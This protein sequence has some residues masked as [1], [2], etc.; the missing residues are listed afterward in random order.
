VRYLPETRGQWLAS[1]IVLVLVASGI[2]YVVGDRE[3]RPARASV[4]VGFLDDMI[5]HHEQAVQLS[6]IQLFNGAER[7][8]TG[9]ARRI[10]AGQSYEI[11]LM[12]RKLEEWHHARELRPAHAMAWMGMRVRSPL[13]MPGMASESEIETLS[14]ATGR[15]ND[16]LFFRLMI[17]HHNGGFHMADYAAERAGSAWI[18]DLARRIA[19]NQR[20]EVHEMTL[21]RDRL[22]LP[23]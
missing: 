1:L 7:D 18:R 10:V 12:H 15:D 20:D 14:R 11:G 9:F 3:S 6:H 5:A 22:G 8:V 21:A 19:R 16:A 2:G 17:A 4:D 23:S 13:L